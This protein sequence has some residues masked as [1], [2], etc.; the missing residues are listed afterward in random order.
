MKNKKKTKQEMECPHGGKFGEDNGKLDDCG[1]DCELF[2]PCY[3]KHNAQTIKS[4]QRMQREHR[5]EKKR[6][7]K[8][9][10]LGDKAQDTP[11]FDL[12]DDDYQSRILKIEHQIQA[13][14][15]TIKT[16]VYN[17]G[18]LLSAAKELVPNGEFQRWITETFG[19]ELP[20][21][22]A[23][24]YKSIYERFQGCPEFVNRL[25]MT[26]LIQSKQETFP[27]D[28]IDILKQ[29]TEAAKQVDLNKIIDAYRDFKGKKVSF[30]E[31]MKM[32]KKEIELG[33]AIVT[34][35][36]RAQHSRRAKRLHKIGIRDLHEGIKKMRHY[37]AELRKCFSPVFL[38]NTDTVTDAL[39]RE[40][41]EDDLITDIDK[42]IAELQALR[43]A[44]AEIQGLFDIRLV[45]KDGYIQQDA[46]GREEVSSGGGDEPT[47]EDSVDQEDDVPDLDQA[48]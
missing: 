35:K 7:K 1:D 27:E 31:F 40:C 3:K 9:R 39:L 11:V 6:E 30:D 48:A 33:L 37:S 14:L 4:Q 5:K 34:G 38:P 36:V 15:V 28:I 25:P 19:D 26:F 16:S 8:K 20:Y 47:K 18:K 42:A 17:I 29:N 10:D 21:S 13:E 32:A 22:T 41:L 43:K 44:M 46:V 12:L 23:A 45:Q 24:C 2:K